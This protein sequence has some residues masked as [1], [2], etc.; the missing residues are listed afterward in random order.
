MENNEPREASNRVIT[1]YTDGSCHPVTGK[2]SWA[3]IILFRGQKVVLSGKVKDTTHQ[4]MELVA[5]IEALSYVH[6]RETAGE[7]IEIFTDSQY[8]AELPRRREKLLLSGF[9]TRKNTPLSNS[10]LIRQLLLMFEKIEVRMIKVPS[11]EKNNGTVNY[12]READLWARKVLRDFV[13]KAGDA[14]AGCL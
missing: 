2:G 5:A 6:L 1:I 8:L 13:K 9:K 12:N 7:K 4:R 14:E 11:H 10:D 3:A